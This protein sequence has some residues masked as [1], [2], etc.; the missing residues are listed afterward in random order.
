MNV[1][2]SI[3]VALNGL[4]ANKL[5]SSLTMLGIIIGVSAVI[6]LLSIGQGAQAAITNEIQGI[7]S[8]L[9]VVIPGS[10]E[11][12]G[13]GPAQALG[14]APSLTLEDAET[15]ADPRNVPHAASVAPS[16]IRRAQVV[17]GGGMVN[18]ESAGVT[19]A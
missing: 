10:I 3:R 19:P 11:Q 5:R 6:A 14:T 2:E 17:Y 1:F 4:T 9:V 15:L 7:G 12:G 16:V 18:P 13:G 8:N